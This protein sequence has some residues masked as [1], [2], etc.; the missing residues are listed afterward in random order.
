MAAQKWFDITISAGA[1]LR[2][3]TR[4]NLTV[5]YRARF[6]TPAADLRVMLPEVETAKLTAW[7]QN[8]RVR[9]GVV[10]PAKAESRSSFAAGGTVTQ[11][12]DVVIPAPG[13][14]RVVASAESKKVRPDETT[15]LAQTV[16][17]ETLWLL[18]DETGGRVLQ[19]FDRN[20]VPVGFRQQPGPFR[21]LRS[22]QPSPGQDRSGNPAASLVQ[23][24]SSCGANEVCLEVSYLDADLKTYVATPEVAYEY[25]I[26]DGQ[27]GEAEASGEGEADEDGEF[28]VG[29]PSLG[30]D[31]SGTTSFN[32]AMMKIVPNTKAGHF[33]ISTGDCGHTLDV[34]VSADEGRTWTNAWHSIENSRAEMNSRT[35]VN[36]EVNGVGN[37]RKCDWNLIDTIRLVNADVD[38]IW[39]GLGVFA[40]AHEYGHAVHEELGGGTAI[41]GNGCA[42]HYP[43]S[44]AETFPCAYNEGWAN[45]HALITLPTSVYP[46]SK[47]TPDPRAIESKY[48]NN[49]YYSSGLDGSLDEGPVMSFFYDLFDG[50]SGESHDLL[51]LDVQDVLTVMGNCQVRVSGSWIAP[52]GIDHLIWCLENGVDSDITGGDD[53]F[54]TRT[55]HPTEE[56]QSD[57]SWN[58]THVRK[59]WLKNL[60]NVNG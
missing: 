29:C 10:I 8:Y 44:P 16:V 12:V 42:T 55:V 59:L 9:P 17:H 56:N 43:G 30:D 51:D 60:Y 28:D 24:S 22:G 34:H 33:S 1:T 18:V 41:L 36:I 57:H 23:S 38:C 15:A 32:N 48:E 19:R 31:V 3:N 35:K 2:S 26:Y 50:G 21:K 5:V 13:I 4:I 39:G 40:F 37:T 14:Y 54:T 46:S 45:Y 7:D 20:A 58:E 27:S 47:I 6:A 52:T 11:S 53:Y 25:T 49:T